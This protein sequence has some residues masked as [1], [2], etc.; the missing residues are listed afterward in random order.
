MKIKCP[1]CGGTEITVEQ[2]EII[3]TGWYY[4]EGENKFINSDCVGSSINKRCDVLWFTC[5]DCEAYWNIDELIH[6]F[7]YP[8]SE[9]DIRS[10]K[11]LNEW[12]A[13]Q[14]PIL[15]NSD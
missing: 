6:R 15:N 14:D 2:E 5:E 8:V 4:C 1:E 10:V 12:L 3:K 7:D 13:E 9:E 11:R